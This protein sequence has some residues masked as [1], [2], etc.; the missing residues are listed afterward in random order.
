MEVQTTPISGLLEVTAKTFPDGRGWFRE[1]F[2]RERLKSTGL[3][4]P[5]FV[6]DN[7]SFSKKGVVRGLHLQL[8][9]SGQAKFVSVISGS[10]LDV[11]VDLRN[12]SPTFGETYQLVLSSERQN[13][14]YIPEG[15]AH[16]FAALEDSYFI[17]KCSSHYQP[18]SE[19][20]IRW[21]DPDLHIN[22]PFQNPI[23]SDKDRELPTLK[24]LVEKSLIS[25]HA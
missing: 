8:P 12:G 5:D 13:A 10:V 7:L 21:N 20:G 15:F 23:L 17:Y 18:Q 16:G 11:V 3:K 1:F 9:P 4:F 25:P 2:N 6:Q 24:Q 22:W 19:T 14:F